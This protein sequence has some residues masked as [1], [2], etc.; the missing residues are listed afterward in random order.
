MN[1]MINDNLMDYINCYLC[2]EYLLDSEN[3]K[4]SGRDFH[5]ECATE[6]IKEKI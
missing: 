3:R 1:Q 5:N 6:Y 4:V 2:E